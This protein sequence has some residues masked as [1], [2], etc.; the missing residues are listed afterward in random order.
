MKNTFNFSQP[1]EN[2]VFKE[3]EGKLGEGKVEEGKV[4]ER[5]AEE[6]VKSIELKEKEEGVYPTFTFIPG[7]S[8]KLEK[9][10]VRNSIRT[11]ILVLYEECVSRN[12]EG[13]I[14]IKGKMII[15]NE[16]QEQYN[17][18]LEEEIEK[19]PNGKETIIF[20]WLPYSPTFSRI[21]YIY[22]NP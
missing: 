9:M 6:G 2:G 1:K 5:K 4:E 3:K 10:K 16:K 8:E 22:F 11:D 20:R 18:V 14:R 12:F 19:V 15:A 7:K 17:Q 21:E 13:E